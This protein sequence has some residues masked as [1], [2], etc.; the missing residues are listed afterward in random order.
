MTN[1]LRTLLP[2]NIQNISVI[3]DI[4]ILEFRSVDISTDEK[5]TAFLECIRAAGFLGVLEDG[6]YV[7]NAMEDHDTGIVRVQSG[8]E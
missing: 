2:W 5:C 7:L 8:T 6:A 4:V 1:P 3:D